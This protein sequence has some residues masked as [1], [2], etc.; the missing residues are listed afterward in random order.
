MP[1]SSRRLFSRYIAG[2]QGLIHRGNVAITL[3]NE[4]LLPLR[5]VFRAAGI[6]MDFSHFVLPCFYIAALWCIICGMSIRETSGKCIW[7]LNIPGCH[8]TRG[9]L[10]SLIAGS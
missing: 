8:E 2:K 1:N 5:Y 10:F 3:L 7:E 9:I 4:V 6:V